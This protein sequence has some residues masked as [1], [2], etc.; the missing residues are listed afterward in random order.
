[1]S[2]V[3]IVIELAWPAHVV[4]PATRGAIEMAIA[5]AALVSAALIRT[6]F[7]HTRRLCEL[8]LLGALATVSLSDFAFIGFPI[9]SGV[10]TAPLE[11]SIAAQVIRE[12]VVASAFLAAALVPRT[13]LVRDTSRSVVI[14]V[15]AA[16]GS[17]SLVGLVA[18]LTAARA[19]AGIGIEEA[20]DHPVALLGALGCAAGLLVAAVFFGRRAHDEAECGLLAAAAVALAAVRLQYLA[21]PV[22]GLGWVMPGDGLRVMAYA[23]LLVAALGQFAYA[24]RATAHAA[25]QVERERIAR[26][27]HDGIAQDLAFIAAHGQRFEADLGPDHPLSIAAGRALTTIRGAI[28]D[29]CASNAPSTEGALRQIA[30]EL[31]ARFDVEVDVQ[32]ACPRAELES[33]D[34]EDVVRIAREAIVNAVRHGHARRIT[35]MLD[36]PHGN[37]L[38]RVLD[39]GF[40]LSEP[41]QADR[42]YGFGLPSMR[43]RAASLG[44][45]LVTRRLATGG[46]ELEVHV[47]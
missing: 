39:D 10:H 23:L 12:V 18:A 32:V 46:T 17:V 37:L 6:H 27:L 24:R 16:V 29:L 47:P 38:L 33:A 25:M 20:L 26:D 35:V 44:G 43:A 4:H 28:V 30:A 1:V 13:R 31:E 14:A 11:R 42:G 22:T 2:A 21:F 7:V 5:F 36:S 45:A 3:V 34:R 41:H 40:G 19:P 9:L 8:L 15:G